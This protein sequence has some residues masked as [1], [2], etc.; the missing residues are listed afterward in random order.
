[1]KKA[2]AFLAASYLLLLC[3]CQG[4]PPV[5]TT[6]APTGT[7][8]AAAKELLRTMTPEQGGDMLYPVY[9]KE[10][11]RDMWIDAECP[12]DYRAEPGYDSALGLINQNGERIAPAQYR[13][14][15]YFKDENARVQYVIALSRDRHCVIYRLD[16][17]IYD[18]FEARELYLF[19]PESSGGH[20]GIFQVGAGGDGI[21]GGNVSIY[22]LAEKKLLLP[23]VYDS[24]ELI[25]RH[26][27]LLS[28]EERVNG[29]QKHKEEMKR[30]ALYDLD[31]G[32]HIPLQGFAI[33]Y[34]SSRL[35][36][37]VTHLPAT[38]RFS[39]NPQQPQ[40]YLT[41]AGEWADALPPDAILPNEWQESEEVYRYNEAQEDTVGGHYKW[42]ESPDYQGYVDEAGEWVWR[43]ARQYAFL[44][45]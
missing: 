35:K 13:E 31:T 34:F 42:Q 5:D 18:E 25:D 44:E 14:V 1:M 24:F 4:N 33:P 39:W 12:M 15:F 11:R 19:P 6:T 37:H 38:K 16:G 45:D 2:I 21:F 36:E 30:Q 28:F 17:S 20:Y 9:Y 7:A 3:A 8:S 22:S 10:Q 23:M 26:T 29:V 41:R 40:G 32:E 27:L 43:E